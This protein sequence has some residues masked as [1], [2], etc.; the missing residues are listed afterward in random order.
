MSQAR[1]AG[2]GA[3]RSIARGAGVDVPAVAADRGD[4]GRFQIGAG[5][6]LETGGVQRRA[7]AA[8]A[9]ADIKNLQLGAPHRRADRRQNLG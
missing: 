2:V 5:N 1:S 7:D 4:A 3:V 8:G 9:G 6:P